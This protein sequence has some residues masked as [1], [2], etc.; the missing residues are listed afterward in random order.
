MLD[1]LVGKKKKHVKQKNLP[2]KCM[3]GEWVS[4]CP[5]CDTT[6]KEWK[7][8]WFVG[9]GNGYYKSSFSLDW[10]HSN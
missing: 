2:L 1:W 10:F 5:W 3:V 9:L 6:K 8:D 4:N 7:L